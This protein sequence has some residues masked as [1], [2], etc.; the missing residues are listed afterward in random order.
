MHY[1]K[2]TLQ[3]VL[4]LDIKNFWDRGAR[5]ALHFHVWHSRLEEGAG[6]SRITPE[7][8]FNLVSKVLHSGAAF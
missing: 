4:N 3:G 7:K 2:N 6:R 8:I 1:N 5:D